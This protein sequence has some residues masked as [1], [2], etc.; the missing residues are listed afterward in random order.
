MVRE[1]EEEDGSDPLLGEEGLPPPKRGWD[2]HQKKLG[3]TW[4]N[5]QNFAFSHTFKKIAKKNFGEPHGLNTSGLEN[6]T[7]LYYN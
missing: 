2:P 5:S 6:N 1:E 3:W 4:K 7:E